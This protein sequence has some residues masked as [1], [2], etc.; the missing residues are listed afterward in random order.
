MK[1]KQKGFII[2]LLI[3]IAVLVIGGSVYYFSKNNNVVA[4][5]NIGSAQ[6][7]TIT[8]TVSPSVSPDLENKL[9]GKEIYIFVDNLTYNSLS[10][11]INRLA[12]DI[13]SDL[14]ARVIVQHST[15]SSGPLEIRNILKQSYIR[16]TLA[17]SILIGSIPTFSRAGGLYTDWF[18]QDLDDDCPISS[19]GTFSSD[20][21]LCNSLNA[22]SKRD[23]F[24]GRI[25][26]AVNATN[27]IL[28]Y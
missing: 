17:G 16:K 21:L 27:T 13:K 8:A 1:N 5:N 26:P 19:D 7:A 23:V 15:Y 11:K 24:T 2:P 20:S 28:T 12:S 25:T 9:N 3:I 22:V 18:Y 4:L 10:Q 6:I 14:G